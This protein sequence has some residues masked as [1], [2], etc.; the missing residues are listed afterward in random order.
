MHERRIRIVFRIETCGRRSRWREKLSGD[1]G[2]EEASATPRGR[3][4]TETILP[5]CL[6][7]QGGARLL[8]T[9]MCD[10]EM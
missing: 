3:T 1:V 2:S 5:H 10:R 4:G 8:C 6:P 9:H 7:A